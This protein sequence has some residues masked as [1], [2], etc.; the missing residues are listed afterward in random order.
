MTAPTH[1]CC[2]E[3]SRKNRKTGRRTYRQ[4]KSQS[5]PGQ[6]FCAKHAFIEDAATAMNQA[7]LDAEIK[8]RTTK[9]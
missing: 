7:A 6:Y 8:S 2:A 1:R 5:A 3:F 4:C 9:E